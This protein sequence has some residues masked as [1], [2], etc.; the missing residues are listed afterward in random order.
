MAVGLN[1]ELVLPRDSATVPLVRHILKYTLVEFGVAA[2]CVS[3]VEL[4][5]T[6]ACANVVEHAIG[7]DDEY[8]IRTSVDG[9]V[10]EIRVIDTGHGFDALATGDRPADDSE[11]GRGLLLMRALMDRIHFESK[12]EQGT[13]V[14]LVKKLDFEVAPLRR[15]TP[16]EHG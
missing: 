2:A 5:V 11:G 13:V 1:L 8:E 4:A 12:P 10:L 3:D 7:E 6:E 14:H 16:P 15:A 9:E